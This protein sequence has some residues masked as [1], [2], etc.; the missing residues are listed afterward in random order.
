MNNAET[1][2]AQRL[3]QTAHV[4]RL[5]A[6]APRALARYESMRV[7]APQVHE[8]Q[9]QHTQPAQAGHDATRHRSVAAAAPATPRL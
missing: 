4:L 9:T 7:T 5:D 6:L 8:S 3:L 2:M 1:A